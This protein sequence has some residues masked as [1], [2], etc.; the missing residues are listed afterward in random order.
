M[1]QAKLERTKIPT[2]IDN[3]TFLYQADFLCFIFIG[4][5]KNPNTPMQPTPLVSL[6]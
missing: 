4:K 2:V 3:P 1:V 5:D 6:I